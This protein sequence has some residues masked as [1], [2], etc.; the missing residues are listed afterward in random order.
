MSLEIIL[1][2]NSLKG[3]TNGIL[4]EDMAFGEKWAE[5]MVD[6]EKELREDIEAAGGDLRKFLLWEIGGWRTTIKKVMDGL[7]GVLAKVPEICVEGSGQ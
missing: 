3:L 7:E 6:L 2:L 5:E 1:N 4:K